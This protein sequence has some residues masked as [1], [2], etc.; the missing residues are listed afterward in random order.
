MTSP[1]RHAQ[2]DLHPV[3]ALFVG[4][5]DPVAAVDVVASV[6]FAPALEAS[7]S[8][9]ECRASAWPGTAIE[10][11]GRVLRSA[12]GQHADRPRRLAGLFFR[13]EQVER[14]WRDSRKGF[15]RLAGE[16]VGHASTHR[17]AYG[18]DAF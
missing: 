2:G 6:H 1:F 4:G 14:C 13:D 17:E 15:R 8:A 3:V 5:A 12:E 16:V 11:R 10:R 9:L 18:I 7:V